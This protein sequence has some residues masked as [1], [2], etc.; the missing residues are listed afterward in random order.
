MVYKWIGRFDEEGPSGLYDREREGRPPKTRGE[1]AQEELERVLEAPPTEEGYDVARWTAPRLA[2]HLE[3]KLGTDVHPETVREAL[4]ERM[5]HSWKRP[6]RKLPPPPESEFAERI[7]RI[8]RVVAN[9]GPQ[10][11]VLFEDETEF[12]RFP[13]LRRAW[14]PTGKQR[15]VAVPEQNGKFALY[16]A[17]DVLTGEV[18]AE[19]HP[20]GRSDHTK[21][22]LRSLLGQIEGRIL[23]VW[24][25]ASWHTSKKVG[26]LLRKEAAPKT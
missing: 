17:L 7:G 20:K 4:T 5:E 25:N 11:T 24:D 22:F 21:A 14:M 8:D 6:R 1:E 2:E 19:P 3:E 18:V 10:T 9:A 16:G 12:K 13:P 15:P 26:K 23:L